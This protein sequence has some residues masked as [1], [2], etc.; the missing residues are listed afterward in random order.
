MGEKP[1]ETLFYAAKYSQ[2]KFQHTITGFVAILTMIHFPIQALHL[3][4]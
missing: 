1:K 3:G 4:Y 2:V